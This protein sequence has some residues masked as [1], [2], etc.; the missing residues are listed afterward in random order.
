M[1][2]FFPY[3]SWPAG[4]FASGAPEF[5]PGIPVDHS[6][7]LRLYTLVADKFFDTFLKS[8]GFQSSTVDNR[9]PA[10]IFHHIPLLRDEFGLEFRCRRMLNF[11]RYRVAE[12]YTRCGAGL[13]GRSTEKISASPSSRS[14]P[15]GCVRDGSQMKQLG[16]V[17]RFL[18]R[19]NCYVFFKR[20][21]WNL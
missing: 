10:D 13:A 9:S 18:L 8:P 21:G 5:F 3:L 1:R 17:R 14:R 11:R 15:V 4:H 19:I 2:N 7:P 6:A 20:S 12:S 16:F